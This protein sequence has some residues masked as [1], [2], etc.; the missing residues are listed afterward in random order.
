[1]SGNRQQ[2][3]SGRLAALLLFLLLVPSPAVA[4]ALAQQDRSGTLRAVVFDDFAND[5]SEVRYSLESDGE[6]L[7]LLPT[8][9]VAATSGEPVVVSG[10]MRSGHLVGSVRPTAAASEELSHDVS[11]GELGRSRRVAVVL[12]NFAEE[13]RTPISEEEIR[14]L[15]FTGP[16]SANA[17]YE[18]ESYGKISLAGAI[19]NDGDIFGWYTLSGSPSPCSDGRWSNEAFHAANE[20]GVNLSPY[21]NV[22]YVVALPAAVA[23]ECDWDG[24]ATITGSESMVQAYAGSKTYSH[25]LGHNLGL[26]H[27]SSMLCEKDGIAVSTGG[28]CTFEEYGDHF[29]VMGIGGFR[30]SN[31]RNLITLGVLSDANV[32]YATHSDTYTIHAA[33]L[34]TEAPTALRV[35]FAVGPYNEVTEWYDLEIRE[36][37]GL[38]ENLDDPDPSFNGVSIRETSTAESRHTYLINGHP[39]TGYPTFTAGQTLEGGSANITILSAGGGAATVKVDFLPP[40]PAPAVP[41]GL[42]GQNLPEG[43]LITWATDEESPDLST[44]MYFVYRDGIPVGS[45][46]SPYYLDPSPPL[47]LHSY[48][49]MA[50]NDR[51]L[52]SPVSK[53]FVGAVSDIGPPTPATKIRGLEVEAGVKLEWAPGADNYG[54]AGYHVY[55]DG[56]EVGTSKTTQFVDRGPGIGS[57]TYTVVTEDAAGLL[58]APSAPTVYEVP[59]RIPPTAPNGLYL[60]A[61]GAS[62]ALHW[63]TSSDNVGVTRYLVFRN[64]EQIGTSQSTTFVDPA[65]PMN[66]FDRYAV[67]AEDAA[68]LRSEGTEFTIYL[69]TT[70]RVRRK[71]ALHLHLA[72]RPLRPGYTLIRVTAQD[73]APIRRVELWLNG[74]R[75]D[76]TGGTSLKWVWHQTSGRPQMGR[77]LAKAIDARGEKATKVLVLDPS[78]A[79]HDRRS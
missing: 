74:R 48:T 17:F 24:I 16:K 67:Y 30:H 6:T 13:P 19:N 32:V 18:E 20:A 55:R 57:H 59:D 51:G 39:G 27:A 10:T 33:L 22:I 73:E 49:V 76:M 58:S 56:L 1:M 79:H 36:K 26:H 78:V 52:S 35:P 54:V 50:R 21:D 12:F 8:A 43:M 23:G 60:A 71:A 9:P 28:T 4:P 64:Q 63:G 75:V 41:S 14:Q 66:T 77:F 45:A 40:F 46:T 34:Q 5:S 3:R 61:S 62:V 25:E 65:A 31:D 47:G 2:R 44:T 72:M 29:D 7:P 38:F 37:G 42:Q 68:G 15:V 11:P 53:P 69:E 70:G